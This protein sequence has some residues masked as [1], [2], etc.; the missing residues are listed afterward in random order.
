MYKMKTVPSRK[1]NY[2]LKHVKVILYDS[3]FST[4]AIV[5]REEVTNS[6]FLFLSPATPLGK[7]GTYLDVTS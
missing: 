1:I 3:L 4:H 2:K 7:S 6:Q 5:T